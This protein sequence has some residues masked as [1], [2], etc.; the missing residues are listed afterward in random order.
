M[1]APLSSSS[2]TVGVDIGQKSDPTAIA[3]VE[4]GVASDTVFRIGGDASEYVLRFIQ[5]L[6]LGTPYP[7]VARSLTRICRRAAEQEI[8]FP[9]AAMPGA[10]AQPPPAYLRRFRR[11]SSHQGPGTQ[12]KIDHIIQRPTI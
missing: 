5:R 11:V 1:S 7:E 3:V 12:R 6:P 2:L 4:G 9:R 8:E 10:K